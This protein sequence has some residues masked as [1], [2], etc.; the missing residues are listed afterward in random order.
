MGRVQEW[1][2]SLSYFL[3]YFP[4]IVSDAISY[5]LPYLK[6]PLVYYH[7]T[8]QLCRTDLDNVSLTRV[9]TLAF[10]PSELF[11]F[12]FSDPISCLLH[13]LTTLWYGI[14]ILYSYV[15]HTLIMCRVQE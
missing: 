9:A 11:P 2:L 10:I 1:Q 8:L 15:I 13:N 12:D 4:L 14:I 6:P 7:D 3:N 5:P